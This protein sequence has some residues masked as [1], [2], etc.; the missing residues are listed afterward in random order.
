MSMKTV[1]E[2]NRHI[3]YDNPETLNRPI[4][5]NGIGWY[6]LGDDGVYHKGKFAT[7]SRIRVRNK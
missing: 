2:L 7:Y 5:F 1:K 3:L 4:M 6:S